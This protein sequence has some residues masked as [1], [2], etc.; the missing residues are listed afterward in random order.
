M[1]Q[2]IGEAKLSERVARLKD[3]LL[4]ATP[5][6]D[7][8]KIQITLEV[9]RELEGQ[10]NIIKR[11]RIFERLCQEKKIFIDENPLAGTLTQFEYG[12]YPI[13]EVGCR[14]MKRSEAFSLQRGRA[15]VS[16]EERAWIDRAAEYWWDANVFNRTR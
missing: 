2:V 10:P 12:G 7:V 9:Y 8:Q 6:I 3:R 5:R 14:W 15:V 1:V 11:A 13:P 4:N 16:E